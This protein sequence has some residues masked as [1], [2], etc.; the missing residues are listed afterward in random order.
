MRL[1]NRHES[2]PGGYFFKCI[3]G[4][5]E[6]GN[7][8]LDKL[9]RRVSDYYLQNKLPIP[10]DLCLQVED[11]ICS[12]IPSSYCWYS[13]GLGDQ[14]SRA[15]HAGAK[16]VDKVAAK[17]G[18]KPELEKKARECSTCGQRRRR[19]NALSS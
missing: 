3:D 8:S 4:H 15:I 10:D 1:K 19:L 5:V 6:R 17:V 13:S 12:R 11:Q 16:M 7:S 9:C 2:V 18:A 14:V